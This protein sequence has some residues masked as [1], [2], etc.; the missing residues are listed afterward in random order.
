MAKT[1][2]KYGALYDLIDADAADNSESIFYTYRKKS[3]VGKEIFKELYSR[4]QPDPKAG[5]T[6]FYMDDAKEI[7]ILSQC[8]SLQALL[9]LASDFELTFDDKH[10]IDDTKENLTIREIMDMVIEDVLNRISKDTAE[11]EYRFD[12]S[13]YET[14]L[15]TVKYSNVEAITWVIPSFLQA[16]KY[17]AH[18][19]ETCK[20]EKQLV[21]VISYGLRY[22]N[23]AFIESGEEGKA[24]ALTI[25]WNFTKDCQEPSLYYTYTVCEC[26][27][28]FFNSFEEYLKYKEANRDFNRYGIAVPKKL[29]NAYKEH[30]ALYE[31]FTLEGDRGYSKETGKKLAQYDEYN[32]LRLR[33]I[34]INNGVDDID[35]SL[36]GELENKCKRV[37]REIWRLTKGEL[38]D[39]FYYNDL[40]TTLS[41]DDIGM[42]TTSDALF[43]TVYIINILLDSGLDEDIKRDREAARNANDDEKVDL[44]DQDYNNLFDSCQMA[45]QKAFRTYEKLQNN[46][47]EYIVDQFLVGFNENFTVHRELIKDLRKR[48][49]RVF[50]LMPLLI[51]TN[52]VI[53]EYLVKYPQ[54]NMRKYLGYILNNRYE[55]NGKSKW[56]WEKDGYFSCSN[57]YYVSALGEFYV[58]YEKYESKF[59]KN[60]AMNEA[61]EKQIAQN[62]ETD[63]LS[64][65]GK[66]GE[67]TREIQRRDGEIEKLQNE[68]KNVS[69][70][71]EDAVVAVAT[72]RI[73]AIFPELLTSFIRE[74]ASGL[75]VSAIDS[76]ECKEAHTEL[77][78]AMQELILAMLSEKIYSAIRP[79]KMSRDEQNIKYRQLEG[80]VKEDLAETLTEYVTEIKNSPIHRSELFD[81]SK[82]E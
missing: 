58:Y 60:Y 11:N 32:E 12:A 63:L 75:T 44:A 9:L 3:E 39:E 72:E 64:P 24:N 22:M 41:E 67:M 38:A 49:M 65:S 74:A 46:G 77:V 52:N 7:G 48:R 50:S 47:K 68:L 76:S 30:L 17:H 29:S 13:P 1:K 26:F 19:G 6:G 25:G 37:A 45:T 4:F 57:Y 79:G 56:I 51:R 81:G 27:V 66:L 8:Q 78:N 62:T 35:G 59:I 33:Y 82:G 71:I 28:D 61:H 69:K 54:V 21:D 53:S 14:R 43:N 70:P 16:L 20:W 36:Y 34:E 40:H 10:I 2:A 73:K 23:D 15:F 42:A 5:Q 80:Y 18:K 31:K 55:E